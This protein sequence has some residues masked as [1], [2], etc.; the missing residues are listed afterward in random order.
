MPTALN[1][2]ESPTCAKLSCNH[3]VEVEAFPT[4]GHKAAVLLLSP[5][6]QLAC[7][8]RAEGP[9]P[10]GAAYNCAAGAGWA[11]RGG[12]NRSVSTRGI[13]SYLR[14]EL[15]GSLRKMLE[16]VWHF[17]MFDDYGTHETGLAAFKRQEKDGLHLVKDMFIVEVADVDTD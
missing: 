2:E 11:A 15:D 9:A 10:V 17:P 12:P 8:P 3:V 4:P 16:G 13:S 7:G 6:G 14:P 1:Q 5:L